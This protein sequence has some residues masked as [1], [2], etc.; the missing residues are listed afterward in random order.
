[1]PPALPGGSVAATLVAHA[2]GAARAIF[3]R[4][5]PRGPRGIRRLV[6][7]MVCVSQDRLKPVD[8]AVPRE[9]EAGSN[10]PLTTG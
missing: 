4:E 2:A 6:Q 3:I 10:S 1:M 8:E 7:L 9:E 5:C